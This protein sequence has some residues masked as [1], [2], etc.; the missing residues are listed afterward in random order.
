MNK[1]SIQRNKKKPERKMKE[2]ENSVCGE[3]QFKVKESVEKNKKIKP[4][5]VFGKDYNNK[6]KKKPVPKGSHRMPNGSIMKDS[7]MK[8][9][10]KKS[11]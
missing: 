2:C 5:E 8:K 9:S 10:K 4:K 11:Y 3:T 1:A 6:S 7:D